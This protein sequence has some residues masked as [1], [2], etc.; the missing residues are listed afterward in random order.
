MAAFKIP[1]KGPAGVVV[2]VIII[3]GFI[4]YLFFMPFMA[5]TADRKAIRGKIEE[6]RTADIGRIAKTTVDQYKK[7][8]KTRDTSQDIKDLSGKIAITEMEGKNPV[9]GSAKV[10]VTYT[11]DGKTPK[12]GGILYFRL[13]RRKGRKHAI[14]KIT[15]VSQITEDDYRK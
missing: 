8:G 1:I 10:K 6:I 9:F 15:E 11:L 13:Y 12:D 2:L 14:R 3:I 4:Y 5:T 7:T